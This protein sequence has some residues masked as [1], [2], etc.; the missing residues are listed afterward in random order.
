MDGLAKNLILGA[1]FGL[2]SS[3][4]T[5]VDLATREILCPPDGGACVKAASPKGPGPI[6]CKKDAVCVFECPR[7]SYLNCM[8]IKVC[9]KEY[10]AWVKK[11]CPGVTIVY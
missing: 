9:T 11:N 4:A 8:P 6:D 7:G 2:L 1:L 5:A 10:V 3:S